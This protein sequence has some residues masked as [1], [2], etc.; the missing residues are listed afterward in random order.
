MLLFRMG[1]R[2]HGSAVCLTSRENVITSNVFPN[3]VGLSSE[4][5]KSVL[6]RRITMT[7]F[8]PVRSFF[9]ALALVLAGCLAATQLQ[10]AHAQ[11]LTDPMPLDPQITIG[12]FANG[13]HYY[14]R[15]NKKPEKRAEL[16]L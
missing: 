15:A 7:A 4:K 13:L 14:I 16:R 8:T 2:V 6:N 12:K 11:A 1:F 9:L 5:A 3:P 10:T